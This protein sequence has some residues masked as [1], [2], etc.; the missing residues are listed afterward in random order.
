MSNMFQGRDVVGWPPRGS[1]GYET[2]AKGQPIPRSGVVGVR[3]LLSG[4]SE[5]LEQSRLRSGSGPRAGG[6][7]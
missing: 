4:G 5:R 3:K 1:F 2:K 6:V 7:I